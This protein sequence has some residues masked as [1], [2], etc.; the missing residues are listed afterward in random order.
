MGE[1]ESCGRAGAPH[2]ALLS[3]G[4]PPSVPSALSVGLRHRDIWATNLGP[5]NRA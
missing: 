3:L 1:T 4:F 5:H 2:D